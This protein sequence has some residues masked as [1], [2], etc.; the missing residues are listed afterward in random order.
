MAFKLS[1]CIFF[2]LPVGHAANSAN[3]RD[4]FIAKPPGGSASSGIVDHECLVA[5]GGDLSL[6]PQFLDGFDAMQDS[7]SGRPQFNFIDQSKQLDAF[8]I[9]SFGWFF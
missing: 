9:V 7:S 8:A 4:P 1:G 5:V 6:V 3:I 2:Q